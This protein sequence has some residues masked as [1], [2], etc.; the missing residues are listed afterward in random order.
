MLE[1]DAMLGGTPRHATNEREASPLSIRSL[2]HD[3]QKARQNATGRFAVQHPSNELP[4][5]RCMMGTRC[6]TIVQLTLPPPV[7]LIQRVPE[8]PDTLG[9]GYL[10]EKQDHWENNRKEEKGRG[11]PS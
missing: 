8:R 6:V 3:G 2:G 11:E 1:Y 9:H 4:R 10:L 5:R 7:L